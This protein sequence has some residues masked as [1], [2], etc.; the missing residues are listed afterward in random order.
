MR[1]ADRPLFSWFAR[2]SVLRIEFLRAYKHGLGYIRI[3]KGGS[4]IEHFS[5][6]KMRWYASQ[7]R[8]EVA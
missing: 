3:D 4:L 7:K 8:I 6:G 5:V 2:F 1:I